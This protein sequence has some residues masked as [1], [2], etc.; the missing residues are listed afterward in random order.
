MNE[1][2]TSHLQNREFF[3]KENEHVEKEYVCTFQEEAF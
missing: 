2:Y 3:P 1:K